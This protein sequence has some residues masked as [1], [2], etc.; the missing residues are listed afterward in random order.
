MDQ[1]SD[2]CSEIAE[3]EDTGTNK[4]S[5]DPQLLS[6]VLPNALEKCTLDITSRTA[7]I[8]QLRNRYYLLQR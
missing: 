3:I 6:S 4:H 5:L 2:E 7:G 8:S 1:R